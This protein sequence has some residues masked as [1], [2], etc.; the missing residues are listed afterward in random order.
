MYVCMYVG[1]V[2]YNF[3]LELG[4]EKFKFDRYLLDLKVKLINMI[5]NRDFNKVYRKIISKIDE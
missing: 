1:D 2:N 5:D 3:Y 4:K